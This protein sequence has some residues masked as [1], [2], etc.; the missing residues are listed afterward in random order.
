MSFR[1]S[2]WA[3][4]LFMCAA[5]PAWSADCR[6]GL[7]EL[8][9]DGAVDIAPTSDSKLRWRRPNGTT[10]ELTEGRSGIWSS[11]A[12]WTGRD[13]G[14][15]VSFS[16]CAAGR[17][18]FDGADGRRVAL[19]IRDQKFDSAG[20]A[21]AGRLV[22]PPGVARVPLVIL[23]HGSEQFSA[24]DFYALQ[25]MFPS[26]G[27]GVFVYDKRGTG[28]S[29]GN[30][31]HD[32]RVLAADAAE[33]VRAARKLAGARA[34][35]V[36]FQGSS[37]GGWVAPL[38][39]TMTTVDFV[40]VS[41]GLAVSPLDEDNEAVALDMTRHGF[42]QAETAKAL[43]VARA[44]QAIALSGFQTGYEELDAVRARYAQEPWLKFVRGNITQVILSQPREVLLAQGPVLFAGIL[45][46]Y[47]PM[48]V[49]RRLETPQLWILGAEDIDAPVAETVR[50]LRT[51]KKDGRPVATVVYPRAEHGMYEFEL[52]AAGERLSLRQPATYFP[53]MCDFIRRGRIGS[54]Y[55]D[56]T[57]YR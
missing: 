2:G 4:L 13:D 56:G 45:P 9:D 3:L 17:I 5:A 51:L 24:L 54:R 28:S 53:L 7:Y 31:T 40:V 19:D 10:G 18:H 49:L 12:G 39:A 32:Y 26:A 37:Q 8:D 23:V 42:G 43:E 38:A 44:A 41:Y 52:D 29:G 35:R 16:D 25:R 47:D 34:G 55:A 50:R 21:L 48:P 27:I 33:A 15:R 36:G 30:Y 11:T 6:I 22:M 1:K 20:V 57:I 46:H 14:R